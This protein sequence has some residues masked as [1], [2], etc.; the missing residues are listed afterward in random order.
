M[1]TENLNP[2]ES[3]R[4]QIKAACETLELESAVYELLNE[5]RRI[6][7]VNIPVKMDDGSLK[8]FKGYR[9]LYNDA[10]GPGM[11]SGCTTAND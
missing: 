8:V 9:S 10:A 11:L 5:P 6:T 3:A 4:K 7:E 2:F 1:T